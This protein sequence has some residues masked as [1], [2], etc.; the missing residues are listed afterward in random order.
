MFWLAMVPGV[1]GVLLL[2][3]GLIARQGWLIA[4]SLPL[5]A[6]L[7]GLGWWAERR[8]AES[9]FDLESRG[10][11]VV[12]VRSDTITIATDDATIRIPISELSRLEAGLNA[13]RGVVRAYTASGP[14]GGRV[15]MDGLE[16]DELERLV[17]AL[18]H[19]APVPLPV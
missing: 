5:V 1:G 11:V 6:V 7:A 10:R 15:V 14:R 16:E 13:G 12:E 19:E 17:H 4:V 9:S 8:G 2:E 18:R 3:V